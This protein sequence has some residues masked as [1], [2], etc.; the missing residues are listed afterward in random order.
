M[1]TEQ[2]RSTVR[3]A[4][5]IAG[6]VLMAL[7]LALA[8]LRQQPPLPRGADAP[9]DQFS[10]SR[11]LALERAILAEGDP[12]HVGSP[13]NEVVRDRI[14]SVLQD[15]GYEVEVQ[16]TVA[17]RS[18]SGA[19]ARCA[20][21]QNVI[22]RLPGHEEGPALM[23]L[24][25]YDSVRAGPGVADDASSVVE[26]LE[27][28][29]IL[30]AGGP[31][32]NPVIFL[33]TDAE[34]VGLLGA[35]GFVDGHPWAGDVA[36]ALNLEARGTRGLSFMFETSANNAW[37]VEAYA[38]SVPRPASS[39]LHYEIYKILPN[40]TDLTVLRAAGLAGLNFAF[41][42][43]SSH[44]HTRLDSFENLDPSSVQHQ[45][46]SVLAVAREL[47]DM[48]LSN[49]APG[50]A[51]WTDLLG[52][53]TVWWPASWTL[54]LAVLALL[55]LLS[56]AAW[57]IWRQGALTLVGLLLGLLAALLTVALSI[58]LGLGLTALISALAGAPSPWYAYPLATRVAVWAGTFLVGGLVAALLA[59]RA[60]AW[61]LALGAWLLW[62]I[63]ALI[64]SL[65][66]AGV[67]I[68]L[69]LPAFVAGLLFAVVA[70]TPLGEK[71]WAREVAF[72]LASLAAGIIWLPLALAFENAVSFD[73]SPAITFS[74][75]LVA[76]TL[77]P[78]CVL[79]VDRARVHRWLLIGA[80]SIVVVAAVIAT[81]LP[82]YSPSDPQTVDLYHFE[83]VDRGQAYWMAS[84]GHGPLPEGLQDQLSPEPV[85]VF[86]WS[87][88]P[89]HVAAAQSTASD[90][91]SLEVL[92]VEDAGG[93]RLIEARLRSPRGG[94]WI[95]LHV[96]AGVLLSVGV[97]DYELPVDRDEAWH[98][99]YTLECH[100]RACDGL[101]VRLGL[102][103]TDPVELLI[104]DRTG[105]LPVGG[106]AWIEARGPTAVPVGPGDLTIILKRVEL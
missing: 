76:S 86:P 100:G 45:G 79:P 106:D 70:L 80:G 90:V 66:I 23:L 96:P 33:F 102:G 91:P 97:A 24:A 1:S 11:A 47:A 88:Q 72:I 63:L 20:P 9:P 41:I 26:I 65:S 42:D 19:Y 21:V 25:H 105:G 57:L 28:A 89:L 16:E 4:S 35:Q 74:L 58:L 2:H 10:A 31:H 85:P 3:L 52:Y 68:L 6:L 38:R 18:A 15:M 12:H 95:S 83:D 34:E 84:S 67:A 7:L 43:R 87:N 40:D 75:G 92:S 14:A 61:G 5:L 71:S 77:A 29:R 98:G 101:P 36:V 60:G 30:K 49:P 62:A 32:R 50:D 104:I 73:L 59:R 22:T 46:D 93:Q 78:L 64:L 8:V 39:S 55:L 48:D 51:A 27:I 54:P 44:Y 99:Y 82:P 13:Q 69:L 94:D 37:L 56:V 81:L 53:V 103:T 17:C